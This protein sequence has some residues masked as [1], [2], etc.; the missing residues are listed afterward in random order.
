MSLGVTEYFNNY[1]QHLNFTMFIDIWLY[2]STT[3]GLLQ[4]VKIQLKLHQQHQ[5]WEFQL[6]PQSFI[7]KYKS[8]SLMKLNTS[9]STATYIHFVKTKTPIFGVGIVI[10]VACTL[11]A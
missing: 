3:S 4:A 8:Q 2:V 5:L 1:H 7:T 9:V 10:V 11:T 6:R